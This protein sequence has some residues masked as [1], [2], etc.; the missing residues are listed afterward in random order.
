[1]MDCRLLGF[2]VK[3][4]ERGLLIALEQ[5]KEIPFEIKRVFY[6]WASTPDVTRGTHVNITTKH[7]LICVNGSCKVKV[8]NGKKQRIYSLDCPDKGLYIP[9]MVW[10]EMFDFSQDCVLLVL[11]SDYYQP[12]EYIRDYKRFVEMIARKKS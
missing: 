5:N 9:N 4:D 10:K 12:D 7:V 8:D 2:N 3:G 1:M 6:I 11:A